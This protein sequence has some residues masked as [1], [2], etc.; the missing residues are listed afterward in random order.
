M[1]LKHFL[2]PWRSPTK[3]WN[4]LPIIGQRFRTCKHFLRIP[5]VFERHVIRLALGLIFC[6]NTP[7]RPRMFTNSCRCLPVTLVEQPRAIHGHSLHLPWH[8]RPR[9]SPSPSPPSHT[10]DSSRIRL[11]CAWRLFGTWLRFVSH[12]VSI[13]AFASHAPGVDIALAWHMPVIR[14][15]SACHLCNICRT[16]STHLL[17]SIFEFASC[18]WHLSPL[19]CL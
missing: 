17:R 7:R 2:G 1:H 13:L 11:V 14:V 6:S 19:A 16:R 18:A 10:T 9:P 4:L 8:D 5:N 15:T 12:V 3:L